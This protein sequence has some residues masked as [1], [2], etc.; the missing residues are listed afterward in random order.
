MAWLFLLVAGLCETAW[1][2]GLK[3]TDRILA[4]ATHNRN[5]R[6]YGGQFLIPRPGL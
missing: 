5:G 6:G 2:I 3:Y 4:P 1:A